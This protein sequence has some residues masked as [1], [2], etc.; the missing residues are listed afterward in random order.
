MSVG[1]TWR[2]CSTTKHHH[3]GLD[4]LRRTLGTSLDG[5]TAALRDR[6]IDQLVS[7]IAQMNNGAGPDLI[8]LCE[9]E[10]EFV[11]Q[12]LADRLSTVLGRAYSVEHADLSDKRGIDVSFLY[13]PAWLS[14][15][16]GE[17]FDHVVMRRTGTREIVQVN[18]KTVEGRTLS[19]FGNHWPSRSGG[20]YESAGYRKHCGWKR[21]P[22][23]ISG[24]SKCTAPRH[25]CW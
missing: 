19:V 16:A 3:G 1:G 11:V 4:K 18:F 14:V 20:I 7:I 6:K 23:S 5:W 9:V 17:T 2:T 10:N 22:I 8:G 25:Q 24:S 21:W 13:D 12:R 15:P